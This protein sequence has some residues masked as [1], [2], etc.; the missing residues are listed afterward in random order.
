M[1]VGGQKK[2]QNSVNVVCERPLT[3]GTQIS[4]LSVFLIQLI[5]RPIL[6]IL[7]FNFPNLT[8]FSFLIDITSYISIFVCIFI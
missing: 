6:Q 2:P 5:E 7:N 3:A 1:G 4:L 8:C